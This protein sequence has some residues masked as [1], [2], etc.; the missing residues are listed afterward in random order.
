MRDQPMT[1]KEKIAYFLEDM[2]ERGVPRGVAAPPLVRMLWAMRLHVRPPLMAGWWRLFFGFGG[3]FTVAVWL[4]VTA[5]GLTARSLAASVLLAVSMGV[6]F[7]LCAAIYV[8]LKARPLGL[9]AW[10]DYP[11]PD[12]GD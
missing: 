6:V 5:L 10:N 3:Y 8:R 1:S 11:P 12:A 2:R 4:V 7:G 9:V